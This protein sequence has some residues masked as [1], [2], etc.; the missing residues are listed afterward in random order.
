M[1]KRSHQLLLLLPSIVIGI[2]VTVAALY[3]MD[4]GL[5]DILGTIIVVI[6]LL[7]AGTLGVVGMGIASALPQ[8][9]TE[10]DAA[11]RTLRA[12]QRAMIEEMDE[13]VE[14]L[15]QIRDTLKNAGEGK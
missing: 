3:A 6:S 15:G 14:L 4:N 11:A 5:N 7:V 1:S 8:L 13:I 10:E 9:D 2:G 12:S